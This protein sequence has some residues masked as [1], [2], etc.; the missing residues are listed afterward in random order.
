MDNAIVSEYTE[1]LEKK[2]R[3]EKDLSV[4]P[5]GYISKKNISGKTYY[6]LQNR[7]SG[8]MTGEY[9]KKDE[10]DRVYEQIRLRKQY[11]AELPKLNTRLSELEQATRLIGHGLDRRLLLLKLGAGMDKLSAE[12]K[13]RCI[14]F[15]DAMNA[16]EGVPASEQTAKG[17]TDWQNVKMSY[18]SVFEAT[19]RRYGFKT[20][21]QP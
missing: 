16:I 14:S 17:L 6:Y 11:E 10:V 1:L 15:A 18:L 20:E 12:Q 5:Q 21:V 13:E 9:L 4:L 8:K 7:V 3:L 2:A 19:L